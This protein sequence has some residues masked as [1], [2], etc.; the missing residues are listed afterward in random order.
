MKKL[1]SMPTRVKIGEILRTFRPVIHALAILLQGKP[2]FRTL[3][4]S[5]LVDLAVLALQAG[6]VGKDKVEREEFK[7]RKI[8]LLYIYFFRRP[9]YEL[10]TRPLIIEPLLS[11]LVRIDFLKNIILQAIDFRSGSFAFSL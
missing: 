10:I 9:V 4:A 7:R 11:K 6:Y 1:K 2:R 3:L 8:Q 5:V